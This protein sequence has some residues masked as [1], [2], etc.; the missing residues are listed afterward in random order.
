MVHF[1]S[2][3]NFNPHVKIEIICKDEHLY[4]IYPQNKIMCLTPKVKGDGLKVQPLSK[5]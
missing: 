4:F 2:S 3:K 1:E 5:T